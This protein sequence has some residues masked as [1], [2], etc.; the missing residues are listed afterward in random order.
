[1]DLGTAH[2]AP[3]ALFEKHNWPR[4]CNLRL[5]LVVP[6]DGVVCIGPSALVLGQMID[7]TFAVRRKPETSHLEDKKA[8]PNDPVEADSI[9][10]GL[11]KEQAVWC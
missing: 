5:N 10:S 11:L 8:V 1:M 3:V 7:L 6:S 9:F 2:M 4:S